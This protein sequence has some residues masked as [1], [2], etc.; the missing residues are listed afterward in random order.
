M[1]LQPL[2]VL[3]NESFI[4]FVHVLNQ[5]YKLLSDKSVKALIYKSFNYSSDCLKVLFAKEIKTCGLTCDF[6]TSH[7]KSGY[8][9]VTCYFINSNYELK[10]ALIA[11]KL[12]SYPYNAVTIKNELENIIDN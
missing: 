3:Q 8:I 2:Y 1:N 11:I 6:W 12:V 5:Y 7:S 10:E 9:G 4:E